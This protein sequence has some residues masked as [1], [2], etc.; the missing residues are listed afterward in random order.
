MFWNQFK[1]AI[2]ER[3]LSD[4]HKFH[5]LRTCVK[6]EAYRTDQVVASGG[7]ELCEIALLLLRKRYE[8]DRL[9]LR[10]IMGALHSAPS[11][12]NHNAASLRRLVST[13]QDK[14]TC[15]ENLGLKTGYFALSYLLMTKLDQE[16]RRTWEAQL[17]QMAQ[18]TALAKEAQRPSSGKSQIKR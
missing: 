10:E 6:G 7:I 2:H 18:L 3:R 13:F 14:V 16:T 1:I 5:Y 9:I 8:D 17:V 12:Q 4:L 11:S 15:L